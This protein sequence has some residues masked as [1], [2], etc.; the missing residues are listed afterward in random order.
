M[1]FRKGGAGRLQEWSQGKLRLYLYKTN[2]SYM[3]IFAIRLQC[4]RAIKHVLS[5][6]FQ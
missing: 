6:K 3:Q 1:G 2:S 4:A 5:M